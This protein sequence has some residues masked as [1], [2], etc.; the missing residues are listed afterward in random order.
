MPTTRLPINRVVFR[1]A[2][3]IRVAIRHLVQEN[4]ELG[5]KHV[6]HIRLMQVGPRRR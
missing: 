5:P 1:H 3:Q 6:D 4:G 2:V